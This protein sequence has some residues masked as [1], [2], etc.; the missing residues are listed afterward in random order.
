V[1]IAA[2]TESDVSACVAAWRGD[3]WKAHGIVCRFIQAECRR[4]HGASLGDSLDILINN[5][6]TNIANRS[7]EYTHDVIPGCSLATNL[8]SAFVI[9][10]AMYPLLAASGN[11]AIVNIGSVAGVGRHPS[12]LPYA[13]TKAALDQMTRYLAV[14]WAKDGIGSTLSTL[15]HPNPSRGDASGR[16]PRSAKK[17]WTRRRSKRIADPEDIAGLAT[18]LCL[19]AARHI[20]GQTVAVTAAFSHKGWLKPSPRVT[21]MRSVWCSRYN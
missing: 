3:G 18:F 10:R 1:T 5:V 21:G 13:M 14:E 6:G 4:N 2:R 7:T 8:D 15:V 17:C 16:F 20:T 9:S 11:G 12:G 19:P